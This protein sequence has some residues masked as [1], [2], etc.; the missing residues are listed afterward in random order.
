MATLVLLQDGQAVP[1]PLTVE[2]TVLGRHPECQIQLN[3]N[4]VSRKHARVIRQGDSY[5]LEDLGS[6]NG[7][8]INGRKIDGPTELVHDDR[9]KLGP[10]LLRFEAT[11]AARAAAA[12]EETGKLPQQPAVP[13]PRFTPA[14]TV[15][16]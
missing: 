10:I 11:P 3:S 13:Q 4:M 6:G 5:V 14:A 1:C 15:T 2:E 16:V 7:T 9:I 8:F 12:V